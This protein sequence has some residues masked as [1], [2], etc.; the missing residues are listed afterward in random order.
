MGN[1]TNPPAMNQSHA[2]PGDFLLGVVAGTLISL[3]LGIAMTKEQKEVQN[4]SATSRIQS[5]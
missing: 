4:V 1:S 2:A 5:Q 3:F